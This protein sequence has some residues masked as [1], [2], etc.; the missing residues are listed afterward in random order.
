MI[1]SIFVRYV[2]TRSSNSSRKLSLLFIPLI[3]GILSFVIPLAQIPLGSSFSGFDISLQFPKLVNWIQIMFGYY[4]PPGQSIPFNQFIATASWFFISHVVS[5]ILFLI[6]AFRFNFNKNIR[7]T[8]LLSIF[9][10]HISA[11]VT[12][13][14][15]TLPHALDYV[16]TVFPILEIPFVAFGILWL[17]EKGTHLV[18]NTI[19]GKMLIP[20]L[21]ILIATLVESGIVLETNTAWVTPA[22]V[23]AT[24]YILQIQKNDANYSLITNSWGSYP[25]YYFTG[26]EKLYGGFHAD[27]SPGL[28]NVDR[29]LYYYSLMQN[30]TNPSIATNAINETKSCTVYYIKPSWVGASPSQMHNVTSILGFPIVFKNDHQTTFLFGKSYCDKNDPLQ[31]T[32]GYIQPVSMLL[33]NHHY[34]ESLKK[35]DEMI[36]NKK[37][38]DSTLDSYADVL[39]FIPLPSDSNKI[40]SESDVKMKLLEKLDSKA[41]YYASIGDLNRTLLVANNMLS[42]DGS[43]I[44][45]LSYVVLDLISKEHYNGTNLAFRNFQS[46]SALLRDSKL[47]EALNL[48]KKNDL[49]KSLILYKNIAEDDQKT[50]QTKLDIAKTFVDKRLLNEATDIYLHVPDMYKNQ[51]ADWDAINNVYEK[52]GK[53]DFLIYKNLG[54][55]HFDDHDIKNSL[56]EQ[57]HYFSNVPDPAGLL[58]VSNAIL[59]IDPLNTVGLIDKAASLTHFKKYD[60]ALSILDMAISNNP[61]NISYLNDKGGVYLKMKD[62]DKAISTYDDALAIEPNDVPTLQNKLSVFITLGHVDDSINLINNLLSIDPNNITTLT[63]ESI[64]LAT[65]G[66]YDDSLLINDKIL[67]LDPQAGQNVLSYEVDQLIA[68]KK[69]EMALPFLNKLLVLHPTDHA[70]VYNKIFLLSNLGRYDEALLAIN[71]S[72]M[73]DPLDIGVLKAKASVLIQIGKLPQALDVYNKILLLNSSDTDALKSKNKILS[74]MSSQ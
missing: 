46:N 15:M 64:L 27:I 35:Y 48:E 3:V 16:V 42:L 12:I 5:F 22:D 11:Y 33:S 50:F 59:S 1:I 40:I 24:K 67:S 74:Y 62:Y 14:L 51:V 56:I 47:N 41:E 26:G 45:A 23:E 13:N 57:A 43:N 25:L 31:S 30:S 8:L 17:F 29:S 49:D 63:Y 20:L 66:K 44:S 7:Y 65:Q 37:Y 39:S 58:L 4:L 70:A 2:M 32:G 73:Y 55:V 38:D 10:L 19:A 68:V 53:I 69:Y 61:K 21:C 34:V 9:T 71:Q 52:Q 28:R 60:E 18:R 6:G 54:L 72:L 36:E